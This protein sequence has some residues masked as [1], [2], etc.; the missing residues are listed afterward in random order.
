M[1]RTASIFQNNMMLQ[2]GKTVSVWG[3][4]TPGAEVCAKIQGKE[5]KTFVGKD[6]KW[7][8]GIEELTASEE[9]CLVIECGEEKLIY[10]D[11]AVGE[12][13]VAGG[14][15][16]MEF[17]MRYEKHREEEFENCPHQSLRFFDV[18]E[19]CYE[20]QLEEFD[21]S[22]QGVWREA[23][24]KE[25]LEY[26]S[27]D[28]YYFQKEI[29]KELRVPVG[30]IG[31]NWGGTISRAWMNPE[32]VKKVGAAWM[33]DYEDTIAEMDM[34]AYWKKQHG[35]PMNDRGNPF[36]DAFGEFV[37][38]R[39]PER[40]ELEAFFGN[41]S[42]DLQEYPGT[43]LPQS[44]PGSLYESMLKM[45]APYSIRGFLWYQGESD[46]VPGKNVLYK[47][48]LTGLISDWRTLWGD[49]KLPF[50][51]VQLPGFRKWL[52]DETEN[53]YPI[54]RKC[55]QQVADTVENAYLCSISDA[56]EEV[57]IHPK[58]KKIVGERLALLAKNY[59]YH[60]P[61]MCEAPRAIKAE[62]EGSIIKVRFDHAADGLKIKGEKLNALEVF[63]DG[64]P[65]VF[66][67][68]VEGN[69]LKISLKEATEEKIKICFAQTSWF[70]VNLYN[71]AD[72]PAVP[73]EIVCEK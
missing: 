41:M 36:A 21:Y 31:C 30:V 57:D 38:P 61:C 6:G 56:G 44:I 5:G 35:N 66:E 1:L 11:V 4:G 71:M 52:M 33:H 59:V 51:F 65:V 70:L 53:Q 58:N 20:R 45:I 55:Q 10:K 3:E 62:K 69:Q 42:S 37:L 68:D 24:S 26:F 49:I 72:V 22:R 64:I 18:P 60:I 7:M 63:A 48:M 27:A 28:G 29:Q 43:L 39:T 67:A 8:L 23:V 47:E 54:I 19:I 73:F 17:W 32:T 9:E 13:W 50:L 40:N 12:V 16:N 14:Q 25:E 15:S 34:E 2:R 46:D